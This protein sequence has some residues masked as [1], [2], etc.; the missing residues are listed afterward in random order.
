MV[1]IVIIIIM[2]KIVIVR[3]N[4][5]VKLKYKLVINERG[6]ENLEKNF[7]GFLI[8]LEEVQKYKLILEYVKY[9]Y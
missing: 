5:K 2:I 3:F 4:N 8:F 7:L 9:I 6:K 1:K